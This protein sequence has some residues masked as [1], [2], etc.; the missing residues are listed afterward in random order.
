MR[1]AEI[2]DACPD[3]PP[4]IRAAIYDLD[5][6]AYKANDAVRYTESEAYM[7][8]QK[9]IK[10]AGSE[11]AFARKA[12]IHRQTLADQLSGKRP[13]SPNVLAVVRIKRVVAKTYTDMDV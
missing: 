3:L 12:G 5:A 10:A 1:A 2:L 4:E 6:R 13:L 9:G 8:L 7:R 11:A